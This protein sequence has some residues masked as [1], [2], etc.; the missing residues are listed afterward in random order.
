MFFD[1]S[2]I[3]DFN[4][5]VSTIKKVFLTSKFAKDKLGK[6]TMVFGYFFY[7]MKKMI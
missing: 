6:K 4:Q 7:Y 5:K 3:T 2:L 1:R